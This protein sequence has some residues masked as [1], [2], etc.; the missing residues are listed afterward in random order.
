MQT[1]KFQLKKKLYVGRDTITVV[2]YQALTV[3]DSIKKIKGRKYL[4]ETTVSCISN[5]LVNSKGLFF[6]QS[7]TDFYKKSD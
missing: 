4:F 3:F 7:F 1:E 5:E 2:R 6:S